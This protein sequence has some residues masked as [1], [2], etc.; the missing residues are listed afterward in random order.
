MVDPHCFVALARAAARQ[1]GA[2]A[3]HLQG[4]VRIEHK[5]A[6]GIPESEV[7]TAVDRAAQDVLLHRLYEVFPDIAVD[8]EEDT[9]AV[10]L[11]PRETP[12]APVIVLDPVDGTLAYTKGSPDW[13]VML[14][15]L[16]GGVFTATVIDFPAHELAC[17]AI[18]GEGAW[19]AR[20][21]GEP[22]RIE[23]PPRAPDELLIA[24]LIPRSRMNDARALGLE[25][26]RSRCSAVDSTAPALGRARASIAGDR[27]DRRRAM[28]LLVTIEAG[29]A[30]RFGERVWR[31]ED[32]ERSFPESAAPTVA[33]D[34][35]ELAEAIVRAFS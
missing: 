26:V 18:R 19:M 20:G 28:G 6:G 3:R 30:A 10:A 4:K 16:E 13:A 24:P 1:A 31:G 27:A 22:S 23:R 9:A 29:G 14:A 32:P 21:L 8:A 11:F 35:E 7:V 25:P 12:G 2:A 15:L 34:S 5:P 33:A 17:W